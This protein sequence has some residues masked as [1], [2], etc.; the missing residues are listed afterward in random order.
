MKFRRGLFCWF[1]SYLRSSFAQQKGVDVELVRAAFPYGKID[2]PKIVR[3]GMRW[4]S[5]II[6][7]ELG[8]SWKRKS[9]SSLYL[10]C[11]INLLAMTGCCA[12]Y[13]ANHMHKVKDVFTPFP[14]DPPPDKEIDAETSDDE[15]APVTCNDEAIAAVAAVRVGY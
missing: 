8:K 13:C 3:G 5:G 4:H 1:F 10:D 12:D 15:D 6:I 7:P 14:G 2:A 9:L 11:A